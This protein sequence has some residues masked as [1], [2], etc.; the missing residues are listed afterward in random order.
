MVLEILCVEPIYPHYLGV[1]ETCLALR[2]WFFEVLGSESVTG[3]CA[4]VHNVTSRGVESG[5]FLYYPAFLEL[6]GVK[7]TQGS[8]VDNCL[9]FRKT[10]LMCTLPYTKLKKCPVTWST[11]QL[12]SEYWPATQEHLSSGFL[13]KQDSKQSP[14]LQRLARKMKFRL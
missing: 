7:H 14:Q 8:N 9:L 6:E 3:T 12:R 11:E 5:H 13:T 4:T 10:D 1:L 2:Y